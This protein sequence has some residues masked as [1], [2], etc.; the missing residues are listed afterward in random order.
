MHILMIAAENGALK[1][2]KVG[3]IGDVIRDV[4]RALAKMGHQVSVVTP[5]Y[6]LLSRVNPSRA[7]ATVSV[8][9][10][11]ATEELEFCSALP[12]VKPAVD[13]AYGQVTDYL[14]DHPL[15]AA[16]GAGSIYC[17][18]KHAPFATDAHKFSLF[19]V[20]VCQLLKQELITAVDVIHLHDWHSGMFAVLRRYLPTYQQLQSIPLVYTIHNLS[21]QGIRP[22]DHD[23]ASPRTWFP[24]LQMDLELVKD[25][26]YPNCI[27]LMRAGIRLADRVHVVSPG[28]AGEILRPT[29]PDHGFVGGEGLEKDLQGLAD[30]GR[31]LGI[32]NGCDYSYVPP[33]LSSPSRFFDQIEAELRNWVLN[34]DSVPAAHFFALSV[35]N[36][37]RKGR[38]DFPLILTSVGRVTDQKV[39]LLMEVITDHQGH[40]HTALDCLLDEIGDGIFILLGSGDEQYEKFFTRMMAHRENFLFLRGFSEPLA[41]SLYAFGD[42][43]MMPSSYEPCGISQMLAMRA[44]TPCIVHHVGGLRDTVENDVNGFTFTGDTRTEQ[45]KAMLAALRHAIAVRARPEDWLS[46][47]A[48]AARS[49]FSWEAVTERYVTELYTF[50]P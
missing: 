11:G 35:L 49:R 39:R 13:R 29:D 30:E 40:D 46:V 20:G 17:N 9:F 7:I 32:L 8:E 43:F 42:L 21:I 26:R 3:G 2:G 33:V 44:G 38:S 10:S 14:L 6:G 50:R 16:C 15:F 48:A 34:H 5:A 25:P 37:W 22:L 23:S 4:P 18:D 24:Q 12:A 47:C 19:C 27:N 45:A 36:K 28:Y 1:G 31:L 41:E